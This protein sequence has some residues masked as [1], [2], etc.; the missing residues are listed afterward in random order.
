MIGRYGPPI[1]QILKGLNGAYNV[2]LIK[3]I[4]SH[5]NITGKYGWFI[6]KQ[7]KLFVF[8]EKLSQRSS[9]QTGVDLHELRKYK[10]PLPPL[11]EQS[12]IATVLSDT[13]T[14]I[15]HLDTL[16][17]KKKAI[18]QGTMQQLLTGKKRLPGFTGKWEMKKLGD[19]LE[20]ITDYTANG[21]FESLK[22]NVKY[23]ENKNYAA[24]VRT[25]DLGKTVFSPERFT[26]KKGYK[27]LKK[28]ALF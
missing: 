20:T 23:Y 1:F 4:P 26:D 18:K 3:A 17:T 16:I 7:K 21:S 12:A 19:V 11:P 6:M 2:A 27:F 10:I 25:T 28:T 9:G 13:D 15:E 22:N 8:V 14:L 5:V 24:L